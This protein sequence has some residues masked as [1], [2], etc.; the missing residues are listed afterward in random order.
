MARR[1]S[2][3]AR[4]RGS[5]GRGDRRSL[6]ARPG[7]RRPVP[8]HHVLSRRGGRRLVCRI[9]IRPAVAA[10]FLGLLLSWYI[11]IP[12]RNSWTVERPSDVVGLFV[13]VV[14]GLAIAG[15]SG[16][17]HDARRRSA[18]ASRTRDAAEHAERLRTTLASIGDGV[19]T[20]DRD[21]LITNMNG[22]AEAL[23]G[24]SNA[25]AI[26]APWKVVFRI[27]NEET[28]R[29]GRQPRRAS[30]E[31][32]RHRRARQPY[33]SDRQGRRRAAHRRQAAPIRCKD[34]E[35]VGCVL[36]FRTSPTGVD[37]KMKRP[38]ACSPPVIWLPSS[39]PPTTPSSASRST[40]SFKPGTP[41]VHASSATRL[42]KPWD[43]TFRCSIPPIASARKIGSSPSSRPASALTTSTRFDSA[44]TVNP[45]R[46]RSQSRP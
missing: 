31:A 44:A 10:T 12:T 23:T 27:V 34:G 13:F 26:G 20:T 15:F 28:A 5:R 43:V 4:Q 39:N 36:V 42:R 14:V 32:G 17:L 1:G 45:F 11:F 7:A 40:A 24:W 46:S 41:C 9:P 3:T 37:R 33:D 21:G 8:V 29:R 19:I 38:T 6:A 16:A 35:I 25:E 30:F 22:V 2:G 18:A